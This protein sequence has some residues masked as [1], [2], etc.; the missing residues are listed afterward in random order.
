M[1]EVSVAQMVARDRAEW[2]QLTALLDAHPGIA[3]HKAGAPWT[4]RDIYAH[5]AR[6][7]AHSNADMEAH[8]AG[9]S[10]SPAMDEAGI[11]EINSRWAQEDAALTL[12][13]AR[14]NAFAAFER[15]EEIIRS[16]RPGEWDSTLARVCRYDG[17]THLEMHRGYISVR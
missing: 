7:T 11:E 3:L 13:E 5:L 9:R 12:A 4:N 16:I 6:W 1:D 8:L 15:R 10:M 17:A 14:A 2:D